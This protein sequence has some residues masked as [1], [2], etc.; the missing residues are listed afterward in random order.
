MAQHKPI[1]MRT[2]A[3]PDLTRSLRALLRAVDYGVLFT[4]LDHVSLICNAR[5]GELFGIDPN[6]VV[7]NNVEAVRTMVRTRIGDFES[8]EV[9]LQQVYDDPEFEQ[10][11]ELELLNPRASLRRYTGPVRDE[12]GAVIGRLWTFLDITA[13]V[14]KRRIQDALSNATLFFDPD[15]ARVCQFVADEIGRYYGSVTLISIR[16]HDFMQFHTVGGPPSVASDMPGNRLEESYCQFC[17]QNMQPLIIQDAARDPGLRNLLPVQ[18]GLTRYAGVPIY[19]P[20]GNAIGTLCILDDRS[21]EVL[22]PDDLSFLSLMSM[23]VS[24]EIERQRQI[25]SLR[26][27]LDN[28][29]EE[30]R[31]TQSHL[32]RSEKLAVTG[33]LAASIAHDIRNILSS[34][35]IQIDIG[36][37][38]PAK[39]LAYI[40]ESLGRFN[41]LAHRLLSYAKPKASVLEH[42]ELNCVV[43]RVITLLAPQFHVS[44]VS[45]DV[46]LSERPTFIMGDEGRLEHLIVNLAVNALQALKAGGRV[47]ITTANADDMVLLRVRDDGPGIPAENLGRLFEP[48]TSTR[49][50]GFGLG[51]YSCRQI[52]RDHGGT[53]QCESALGKG[54]SF[55]V[56]FRSLS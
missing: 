41:I 26:S 9:N 3:I 54:T 44:Q 6:D 18:A 34:L 46:R 50:D 47:E 31:I 22:G 52:V 21:D 24:G 30:L 53:L 38:D 42:V 49:A 12:D 37:D 17:L 35:S 45:L 28:T 4:D 19:D 55:E 48:F 33:T 27:D 7:K 8:W 2:M 25:V 23:K 39:A 51:L 20:L 14:R 13:T 5:F 11:D 10:E 1:A 29:T 32:I 16:V 36:G 43:Q 56:A 15:P 40:K